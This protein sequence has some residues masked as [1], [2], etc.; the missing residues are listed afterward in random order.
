VHAAFPF[1]FKYCIE[2]SDIIMISTHVGYFNMQVSRG[3]V[4]ATARYLKA[5]AVEKDGVGE[6]RCKSIALH[7]QDNSIIFTNDPVHLSSPPTTLTSHL[8]PHL[9]PCTPHLSTH[10]SPTTATDLFPTALH[11]LEWY[12]WTCCLKLTNHLSYSPALTLKVSAQIKF[13]E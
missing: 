13:L 9:S 6:E 12:R 3:E 11:I 10:H 2:Y 4:L 5:Q 7:A 1:Q 8:S